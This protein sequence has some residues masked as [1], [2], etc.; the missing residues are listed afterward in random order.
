MTSSKPRMYIEA[1]GCWVVV[2][3]KDPTSYDMITSD[4]HGDWIYGD[5]IWLGSANHQNANGLTILLGMTNIVYREKCSEDGSVISIDD[6]L[7]LLS[8]VFGE[9]ITEKAPMFFDI[10]NVDTLKD[11][12]NAAYKVLFESKAL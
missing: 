1:D 9:D 6:E 5:Q 4:E 2:Y 7:I 10:D 3:Y 12:L 8:Y 11:K